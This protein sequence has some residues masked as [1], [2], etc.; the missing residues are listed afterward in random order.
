MMVSR[1]Q[2]REG[3]SFVGIWD[4][5]IAFIK[6]LTLTSGTVNILAEAFEMFVHRA[7]VKI[8]H[9]EYRSVR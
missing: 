3:H 4:R 1:P 7:V 9:D 6:C 2:R 5:T 8:A